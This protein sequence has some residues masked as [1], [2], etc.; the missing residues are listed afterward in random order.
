MFRAKRKIGASLEE[1]VGFTPRTYKNQGET[2]QVA[3]V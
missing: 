1:Y 3:V 2:A